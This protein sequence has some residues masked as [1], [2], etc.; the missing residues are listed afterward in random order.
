MKIGITERGDAG[1]DFTWYE[2]LKKKGFYGFYYDG[3]VLI[4]KDANPQFQ[5]KVF[6]LLE[7]GFKNIIIHFTCTGWGGTAM[8]PNVPAYG[9]QIQQMRDIIEQGFP[10]QNCVLRIDP[11]IPTTEGLQK[12][13]SVL[14][15]PFIRNQASKLRFR[16]SIL[17][18][19]QHVCNRINPI[20]NTSYSA[21][22]NFYPNNY[23]RQRV[24]HFL[25]QYHL[26]YQFEVCTEPLFIKEAKHKKIYNIQEC[27][28]IS[29]KDIQQFGLINSSAPNY[30]PQRRGCLCLNCKSELLE[31][32]KR[33]EHQ[34]AYCY[35]HD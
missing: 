12:A 11:I 10:L 14:S 29:E 34:C 18:R 2:K 21:E 24:L 1:L 8:E 31:H 28:C 20:L 32:R 7:Q 17:D 15:H 4:T 9:T 27:G 3:A 13:T 35:W 6:T 19:Y 22:R 23:E 33:C 25:Q 26:D 16:I 5:Q 30:P